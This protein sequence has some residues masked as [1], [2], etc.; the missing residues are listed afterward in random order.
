VGGLPEARLRPRE[1]LTTPAEFQQAF[2]RGIRLDGAFFLLVA[3]T[4]NRGH[5]RL[6]LAAGRKVGGAVDRNRA[7]RL[8]R[9]SFRR[10]K[11]TGPRTFDLVLVPKR[12]IVDRTMAEVE[13]EYRRR[14]QR[15]E[16][17]AERGLPRPTPRD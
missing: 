8:L 11:L 2:R 10:N 3:A 15:L 16:G 4:N 6:G 1:R 17:S 9:E 12:E 13:S 14:L 7:K 5:N